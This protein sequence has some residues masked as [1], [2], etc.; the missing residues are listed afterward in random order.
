MQL[1]AMMHLPICLGLFR[2][3]LEGVMHFADFS[4]RLR[5]GY[6]TVSQNLSE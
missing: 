4:V 2:C 1:A 3:P 5:H 6:Y